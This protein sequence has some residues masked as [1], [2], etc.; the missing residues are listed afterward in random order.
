MFCL[1]GLEILNLQMK[2][3][4]TG[5]GL[6]YVECTVQ[7]HKPQFYGR[8]NSVTTLKTLVSRRIPILANANVNL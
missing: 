7:T 3:Q 2:E 8:I 4:N 6:D 5:S 1:L